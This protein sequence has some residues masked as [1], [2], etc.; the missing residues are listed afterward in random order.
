MKQIDISAKVD[1]DSVHSPINSQSI[2]LQ[3]KKIYVEPTL[4][5]QPFYIERVLNWEK[6]IEGYS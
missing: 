2:K 6:R 3:M 1:I 5:E 4:P